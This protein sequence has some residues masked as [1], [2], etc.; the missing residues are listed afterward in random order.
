MKQGKATCYLALMLN[1]L[2][3]NSQIFIR[4]DCLQDSIS[5]DPFKHEPIGAILKT[6][7]RVSYG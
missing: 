1:E 3:A 6:P 2:V 7:D 5:V 4:I